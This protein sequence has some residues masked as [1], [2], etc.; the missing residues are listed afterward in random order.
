MMVICIAWPKMASRT[1]TCKLSNLSP[2]FCN[3][4]IRLKGLQ[5]MVSVQKWLLTMIQV[6]VSHSLE[7]Y[8]I[9]KLKASMA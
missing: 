4:T 9:H 5:L 8:S 3:T 7:T 2:L 6:I 1:N